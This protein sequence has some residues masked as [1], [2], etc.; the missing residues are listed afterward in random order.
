M[1]ELTLEQLNSEYELLA[2]RR[3]ESGNRTAGRVGEL[4]GRLA[5]AQTIL[6]EANEK[7]S[8]A[9][10][11]FDAAKERYQK[12]E[13]KLAK[14][15]EDDVMSH[16]S[17]ESIERD[18]RRA[19]NAMRA[20]EKIHDDAREEQAKA[21]GVFDLIQKDATEANDKM[22][23]LLAS[24]AADEKINN[25]LV[26]ELEI[27]FND[28][29][30]A[31]EN[32][33]AELDSLKTTINEDERIKT[34]VEELRSLLEQFNEDKSRVTPE[35]SAELKN[36][37]DAIKRKRK[38]IRSRLTTLGLGGAKITSEELDAMATERDAQGRIVVAEIDRRI[39]AEDVKIASIESDRES[40]L[41]MMALTLDMAKN[42]ENGTPEF[43]SLSKEI[44]T[45]KNEIDAAKQQVADSETRLGEI[46]E[47]KQKLEE[48]LA[49]LK[50][51]NPNSADIQR[52]EQE[53]ATIKAENGTEVD[54]PKYIEI[55]QKIAD[56]REKLNN[57]NTAQVE[58]Q[59]YI[60]ANQKLID[61]KT[62]LEKEKTTPTIPIFYNPDFSDMIEDNPEYKSL[63]TEEKNANDEINNMLIAARENDDDAKRLYSDLELAENDEADAIFKESKA[64]TKL[65]NEFD[66]LTEEYVGLEIYADL[67][68]DGSEVKLKFDEYRKAELLVRQM[69]IACQKNPSAENAGRLESAIASYQNATNAF[70]NAL[71]ESNLDVEK[72]PT[73]EAMHKYLLGIIGDELEEGITIDEAYNIK[74]VDNRIAILKAQYKKSEDLEFI[75]NLEETSI[76]LETRLKEILEKGT[77]D[78]NALDQAII[79]HA[80]SFS[81]FDKDTRKEIVDVLE[82]EGLP[83]TDTKL[84]FWRRLFAP[85]MPKP[86]VQYVFPENEL[87]D[88][89]QAYLDAS[90]ALRIAEAETEAK[91]NAVVEAKSKYDARIEE[92]LTDDQ[93]TRRTELQAK[94]RKIQDKLVKTPKRINST[95]LSILE[96]AVVAAENNL[97]NTTRYKPTIDKD[98]INKQIGDLETELNGVEPKI[99]DTTDR[100]SR[101]AKKQAELD[102]ARTNNPNATRIAEV[103]K[104]LEDLRLEEDAENA[105]KEN[106]KKE[107]KEKEPKLEEKL[108]RFNLLKSVKKQFE[109]IKNLI[110]IKDSNRINDNRTPVARTIAEDV[111]SNAGNVKEDEEIE[112]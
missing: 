57:G 94:I 2:G 25:A 32:R 34:Q 111:K 64:R 48:E 91:G 41:E 4:N 68:K 18:L 7:L 59:E 77:Y 99:M 53:L 71:K 45:L 93:K 54:N 105:K 52:L 46:P 44:E 33:K 102:N 92:I 85:R 10:L 79:R 28:K 89:Y 37:G 109:N 50:T 49:S 15:K 65:N 101:A 81:E 73:N 9:T 1:E 69:M 96:A 16:E 58:T 83:S 90:E 13:E 86:K 3:D 14:E 23:L 43:Q 75:E 60:D 110:K 31:R 17:L 40:T 97:S 55:T 6:D 24:F 12:L 87:P 11:D 61:A 30:S 80:G 108:S 112:L 35:T 74:N 62:A 63:E 19:E 107:L 56:L 106:A 95:R 42:L 66:K 27:D 67:E 47:E 29:I 88:S 36:L 51:T 82:G 100:D 78:K 8:K 21:V 22:N 5:N 38:Q 20:A 76:E 98:A 70:R 26:N 39:A 104:L 103:T 84:P 72:E